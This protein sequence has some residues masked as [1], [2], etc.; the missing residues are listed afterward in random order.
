MTIDGTRDWKK[1][2]ESLRQLHDSTNVSV[3]KLQKQLLDAQEANKGLAEM[4]QTLE[5]QV[6]SAKNINF[7]SITANNELQQ[8][9]AQ[10]IERLRQLVVSLGGNPN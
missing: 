2:Y 6:E 8:Q 3:I 4:A 5:A 7:L 9:N 10:E 1:D